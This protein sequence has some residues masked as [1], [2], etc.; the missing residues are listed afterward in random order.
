MTTTII[1][2]VKL[3]QGTSSS[4]IGLCCPQF[5]ILLLYVRRGFY[6]TLL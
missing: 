2:C 5:S 1:T 4:G 6:D 3:L